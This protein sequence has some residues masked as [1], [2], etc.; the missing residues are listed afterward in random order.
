MESNIEKYPEPIKLDTT[1]DRIE[2]AKQMNSALSMEQ[3]KASLDA[4]AAKF[5]PEYMEQLSIKC[6]QDD[7]EYPE[8]FS[9]WYPHIK[10]FGKF[11]T[12]KIVANQIFSYEETEQF[13]HTDNFSD[14]NWEALNKILAPT[15]QKMSKYRIYNIKNGCFSNKFDFQNCLATTDNLAQQLWKINYRSAELET[16]GYTE[17]VVREMIPYNDYVIPTIYNGMPL[18]EELRVFYN[19]DKHKIEY[20]EDYWKYNYCKVNIGNKSNQIV[21]DWFHNKLKTR[22]TQHR[23]LLKQL[24]DRIWDNIHT[25]VFDGELKGIWSI[26]FM[27]VEDEDELYLIDM[28]RGF[29]SAYYNFDKLSEPTKMEIRKEY[30]DYKEFKEKEIKNG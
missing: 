6:Y 14:V 24:E 22:K 20:I 1:E 12:A 5:T 3:F 21:F 23:E 30:Q 15:L 13:R 29:R 25:L 18:R 17:L 16:G 19:M 26:D 27:Y 28:A 8:N 7:R 9:N 2:T 10:D 11:K 4:W